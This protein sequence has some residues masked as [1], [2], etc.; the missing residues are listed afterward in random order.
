MNDFR[1]EL[2]KKYSSTFKEHISKFDD[3]S[4]NAT[5]GKYKKQYLSL[6][7]S[8]PQSAKVLDL[9]CGR[10]ILLEFLTNVGYTNALGIDISAEQIEIAKEKDLNVQQGSIIEFFNSTEEKFD[11]IFALDII[12]HFKR[13][14]LIELFNGIYY[15]LNYNG[16]FI[17]NTPNGQGIN[18]NRII[19]GDL[20]HI[21]IFNPYSAEQIL[22]L[23]GF[24]KINFFETGPYAKNINGTIRL[25]LWKIIKLCANFVR[26][27]ETASIEKILTQEFIGAAKKV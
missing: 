5:L 1:E 4:I 8:Y 27:V 2:Y 22:R 10:G 25:I 15:H 14:E 23:V 16:V 24:K 13:N 19:H 6:F 7:N 17:F 3:R 20:T 26:F 11:I 21:T 18:S 12:E 9:G